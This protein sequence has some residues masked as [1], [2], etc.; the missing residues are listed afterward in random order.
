MVS[1]LAL[2]CLATYL[3]TFPK[4]VQFFPNHLVTLVATPINIRLA[5][6]LSHGQ[7]R[8]I[9]SSID[10]EEKR[11]MPLSTGERGLYSD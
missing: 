2:F 3:A 11:F 8:L 5:L 9:F 4:I 10:D 7:Q 1:N 6:R